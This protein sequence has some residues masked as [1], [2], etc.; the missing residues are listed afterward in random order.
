MEM[1]SH[2]LSW[3]RAQEKLD[4]SVSGISNAKH[5]YVDFAQ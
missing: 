1:E 2:G 3:A 4:H 5:I